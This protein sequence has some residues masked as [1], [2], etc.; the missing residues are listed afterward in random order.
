V[1]KKCLSI[2]L[3]NTN[4]VEGLYNKKFVIIFMNNLELRASGGFMGSYAVVQ[5]SERGIKEIRVQDIYVPDGQIVGHVEPPYPIQEAFGQGWWRLRDANWEP[6]WPTAAQ[7]IKWFMEQGGE[8]GIDGVAAVN[9]SSAEKLLEIVGPV[10]VVTYGETVTAQNLGQLAQEYAQMKKDKRGFLG[11]VGAA[12]GEKVKAINLIEL[13][14]LTN[15][16][17]G[18]LGRGEIMLWFEDAQLQGEAERRRWSGKLEEGWREGMEYL[19]IV[20]SNLGV[21]KANCCVT[22]RVKQELRDTVHDLRIEWENKN[23]YSAPRPPESWGGDYRNY[24]RV[25]VPADQRLTEVKV[26][27]RVLR[28]GGVADFGVPNELRQG[29]SEEMYVTETRGQLQQIG[30]WAVVPAGQSVTAQIETESGGA[31]EPKGR[32]LVRHQPG[33]GGM[34]YQLTVDGKVVADEVLIDDKEIKWTR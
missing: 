13:A 21:N 8:T 2:V 25:I 23:P 3:T 20:E 29:L 26:G 30:F 16:M 27:E 31:G 15:L 34:G 32:I 33:S 7:S 5:T 14:K 4:R 28:R 22:R 19:Y 12:L 18:E 11:A 24:V 1:F 10:D 6:D 17:V 9:L